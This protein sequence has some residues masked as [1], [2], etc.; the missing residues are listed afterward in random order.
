MIEVTAIF[1][2][3]FSPIKRIKQLLWG[4]VAFLCFTQAVV[5]LDTVSI[6]LDQLESKQ[7]QFNGIKL[8]L[9]ELQQETQQLVLSIEQL[10]LAEPLADLS[11]FDIHCL[12]FSW[13]DGYINCQAGKASLKSARFQSP[14]FD[15]SF[16]ISDQHSQ[17]HIQKLQLAQGLLSLTA[18]KQGANWTVK[19]NAQGL[20]LKALYALFSPHD[21]YKLEIQQGIL[22]VDA[23]ISGAE[24]TLHTLLVTSRLSHI[25]L[26]AKAGQIAT[27]SLAVD[28]EI[29][30]KRSGGQWTWLNNIQIKQ[31]EVYLEPVYLSIEKSSVSL[32]AAGVLDEK[33]GVQVHHVKY[34]HTDVVELTAQGKTSQYPDFTVDKAHILINISELQSFFSQYMAPFSAPTAVD[35]FQFKG[36]LNAETRI[37]QNAIQQAKL[38]L[39]GVAIDDVK[40]RFSIA[41]AHAVINWSV[42][43]TST[44]PSALSWQQMKIK[45]IPF[46]KGYLDFLLKNKTISLLA[47]NSIAVLGGVFDIKQFD[48]EYQNGEEP[49]VYFEG[50]I[51]QL[52][53]EKLSKVLGWTPL[54]GEI[55]GYFPG[56]IYTNNTLAVK[57]EIQI[58]L[59]DGT[60]KIHKLAS[61]GMLEDFS[62]LY[63]DMEIDNLDLNAI[64]RKFKVGG[65]E[66]RVSGFVNNLYLENWQPISFY[67]W[68][69]TPDGDESRHRISQRAVK[70]LVSIGGGGA[71]DFISKGFLRFFDSFGYDKF[72]F[73]C[74]LHQGVCQL[75][76][77]EAAEQGYYIIKGGGIPR[78]DVIGYNSRLDW[79]VFITR[80]SRISLSDDVVFQ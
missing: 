77:V 34:Q 55:S 66:G 48:W 2:P 74:Y 53:L 15:F 39:S 52:S 17:F 38:T 72:G 1:L 71:A 30:A 19:I 79:N 61:S 59:F 23:Q 33:E 41:D 64:T 42:G 78:I 4:L 57:G 49:T 54:T 73:G 24:K 63:M 70:N 60:I 62:R 13:Q 22:D 14:S 8:S 28:M 11:F 56:V 68:L 20:D 5:A 80:L 9:S 25:T 10:H 3:V 32:E 12:E 67:A 45:G 51:K 37:V 31:G 47:S 65:M 69:G 36:Q 46:D 26:Q 43:S 50:G 27:D 35:E 21:D 40:N 29:Q 44:T 76:G 58:E 75:M 6:E 18:T 7:W 16:L